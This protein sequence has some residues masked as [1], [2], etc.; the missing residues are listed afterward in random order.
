MVLRPVAPIGVLAVLALG[1]AIGCGSGAGA[2]TPSSVDATTEGQAPSD[3]SMA[4]EHDGP[5]AEADSTPVDPGPCSPS[6]PAGAGCGDLASD[7]HNCGSCGNDCDGGAC[8]DASCAALAPG[9]LA[10]GQAAPL[11]I[12]VD[13]TSVYW[14]NYGTPC[15][16]PGGGSGPIPV[17]PVLV[18][19]TNGAILK[20]AKAGCGNRPTVL[21]SHQSVAAVQASPTNLAIGGGSVY[22]SGFEAGDAGPEQYEGVVGCAVAGC[23]DS[24][25]ALWA[26][27]AG[28]R[29]VAATA[30]QVF[31]TGGTT[32]V[33]VASCRVAGCG[34]APTLLATSQDLMTGIATDGVTVYWRNLGQIL[35]CAVGGCGGAPTVLATGQLPMGGSI[36]VDATN[37]YW[38]NPA[39][40]PQSGQVL[41]CAKAGCSAGP[42]ALVSG[43]NPGALA[44]DGTSVYFVDGSSVEKCA[45]SGC[46]GQPATL[47]ANRSGPTAI[48]VD[49]TRV[50][51]A[52]SGTAGSGGQIVSAPK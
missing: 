8:E 27:S 21:A 2:S 44:V 1:G 11:A 34:N 49:A 7:P 40:G 28:A 33:E 46:N 6:M 20:C 3:A 52:E 14:M 4:E 15:V 24:P 43:G 18:P 30:T 5:G 32:G 47:A 19:P 9:I 10:T 48:A 16:I 22:W 35:A 51:W 41:A 31:W 37:V 50:Y 38:S 36:A 25:V 45:A 29:G 12:A 42:T 26:G 17:K 23:N 39:N 13:D